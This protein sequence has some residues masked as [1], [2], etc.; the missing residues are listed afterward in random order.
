MLTFEIFRSTEGIGWMIDRLV[1][2]SSWSDLQ[3]RLSFV[4]I[5][6]YIADP[7]ISVGLNITSNFRS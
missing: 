4:I 7:R 6:N 2:P 3:H 1:T 5:C